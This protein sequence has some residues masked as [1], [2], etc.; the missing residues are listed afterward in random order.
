MHYFFYILFFVPL[1]LFFIAF[2]VYKLWL[3][4]LYKKTDKLKVSFKEKNFYPPVTIQIPVYNEYNVVERIIKSATE[5]NYPKDKLEIQILD[6][7]TDETKILLDEIVSEKQKQGFDI[8]I[9]R[10]EKREGYKAGALKNG[11]RYAKGDF[12]AIFDADFIIPKEFLLRTVPFFSEPKVA[13]VQA[14][15]GFVNENENKLT[16]VESMALNVHFEIEHNSKFRNNYFFNFNGTAGIWRKEAIL[17]AGNWHCDT[18]A[19]DL[20]LSIRAY[21]KGWKFIFLNDLVCPSELPPDL[22][23]FVNQQFRWVKGTCEVGIK[24][25]KDIIKSKIKLEDKMNLISHLFSPFLYV[26][27]ILFFFFFWP[28]S[29]FSPLI[30]GLMAMFFGF[31]NLYNIFMSDLILNKYKSFKQRLKDMYYLIMIFS[32]FSF[33]GT[34]AVLQAVFKK[35]TPFTRTPKK[36]NE[37]KKY[38]KHNKNYVEIAGFLYYLL[39]IPF[40]IK[41]KLWGLLPWILL[42]VVSL[43]YFVYLSFSDLRS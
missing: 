42:F 22:Y 4:Y 33:K 31:A 1:L 26:A 41:M 37:Q 15:W 29:R 5:V 13:L 11:L 9:I 20:D 40:L 12:I 25:F 43:L 14:K 24:L 27:N 23:S 17:D 16:R 10:R 7:S 32:A 30:F 35:R 6:D 18:L 36:G 34:I 39:A 8:K 19:E 28:L 38:L 2:G 21:I 3:F